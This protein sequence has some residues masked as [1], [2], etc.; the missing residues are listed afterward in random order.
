MLG[1]TPDRQTE[2]NSGTAYLHICMFNTKKASERDLR[3]T[4][5]CLFDTAAKQTCVGHVF[6]TLVNRSVFSKCSPVHTP[7]VL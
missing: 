3:G 5:S 2:Y 7:A 6:K 4:E 1:Q